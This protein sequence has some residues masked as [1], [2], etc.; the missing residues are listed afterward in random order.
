[1]GFP[2]ALGRGTAPIS[3]SCFLCYTCPFS[4]KYF[5]R[6]VNEVSCPNLPGTRMYVNY[7]SV[8]ECEPGRD[9]SAA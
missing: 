9:R 8:K 4:R 3:L 7:L 5:E 6:V 2:H 1:M